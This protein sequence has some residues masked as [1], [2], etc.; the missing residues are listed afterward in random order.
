MQLGRVVFGSRVRPPVTVAVDMAPL[1]ERTARGALRREYAKGVQDGM[2]IAL[3]LSLGT[4]SAGGDPFPGTRYVEFVAW[5]QRALE[6]LPRTGVESAP[7][8]DDGL[9]P[10]STGG[11]P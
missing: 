6:R 11:R 3:E 4:P 7:D 8:D 5:A 10:I 1:Y 2:R 9:E